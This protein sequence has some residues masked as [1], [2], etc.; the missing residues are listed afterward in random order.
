[1]MHTLEQLY[2]YR[3]LG[4][5]E[6]AIIKLGTDDIYQCIRMLHANEMAEQLLKIQPMDKVGNIFVLESN[7]TSCSK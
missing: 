6:T 2:Y 4:L 7:K 3:A 5:R 1:M